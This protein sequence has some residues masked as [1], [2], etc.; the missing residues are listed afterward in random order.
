MLMGRSLRTKEDVVLKRWGLFYVGESRI[1]KGVG[2]IF[3]S[4]KHLS[5]RD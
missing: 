3:F 1:E 2:I 4:G 5:K